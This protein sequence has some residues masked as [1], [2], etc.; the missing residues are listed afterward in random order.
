MQGITLFCCNHA[1]IGFGGLSHGD[2]YLLGMISRL[3]RCLPIIR[4][5]VD[6]D[7]CPNHTYVCSFVCAKLC[8]YT[9][10]IE[11]HIYI[12]IYALYTYVHT[13][14]HVDFIVLDA[15]HT[16]LLVNAHDKRCLWLS[17][18]YGLTCFDFITQ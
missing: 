5:T 17:Y 8:I 14:V 16:I 4:Y 18:V 1:S 15:L 12:Y 7:V 2:F 11:L 13:S 3:S 6:N 10:Y 9:V